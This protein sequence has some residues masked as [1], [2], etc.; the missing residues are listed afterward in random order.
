MRHKILIILAVLFG[1]LAFILTYKQLEAEK[2]R[3]HGD[4][5][6]VIL[7]RVNRDMNEG[8]EITEADVVRYQTRRNKEA[9]MISREIPWS[10]LAMVVGRKLATSVSKDQTLQTTDLQQPTYRNSFNNIINR[11]MRAV[12]L[13]V[14]PISSV[15]YLIQPNDNVDVIGTF[16]FPS[17]KGNAE[18][19]T[20]TLTILQDVKVHAVG[21]RWGA[22]SIDPR[23]NRNYGTITLQVYP[24][25]VEM[26]VFAAQKGT[27]SFSL[28]NYED[29]S[30]DRNIESRRVNFARLE[31]EIPN[32]NKRRKDRR[33][34]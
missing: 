14:D 22:S 32:Y 19:D 34:L 12:A 6:H 4:S 21:N 30:I 24:D 11:N 27:L 29:R 10:E 25:E 26:L 15:N 20:I 18:L 33:G 28:R 16:R 3:I 1:L 13:P 5:E 23:G 17:V 9:Q 7:I 31:K 2:A 8:E